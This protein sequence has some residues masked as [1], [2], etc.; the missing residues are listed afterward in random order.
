MSALYYTAQRGT[1]PT[2]EQCAEGENR[3]RLRQFVGLRLRCAPQ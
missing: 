2:A 3:C 1:V